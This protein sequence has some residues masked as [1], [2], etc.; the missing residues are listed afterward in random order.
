MPDREVLRLRSKDNIIMMLLERDYEPA[1]QLFR[2]SRLQALSR[3]ERERLDAHLRKNY[4][5]TETSLNLKPTVNP[6][7]RNIEGYGMKIYKLGK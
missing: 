2:E 1:Q 7:I 6:T 5:Y 3:G 4:D